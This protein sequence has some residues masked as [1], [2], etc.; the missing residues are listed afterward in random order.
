MDKAG[1]GADYR[2]LEKLFLRTEL[3]YGIKILNGYEN[4][5]AK[6]WKEDFKGMTNGLALSVAVGY[7]LKVSPPKAEPLRAAE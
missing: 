3:L 5:T 1:V 6:Y 2:L 7:K 4:D